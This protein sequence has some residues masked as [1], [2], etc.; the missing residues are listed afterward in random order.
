MCREQL[1][2]L[3]WS[4]PPQRESECRASGVR[5]RTNLLQVYNFTGILT[6]P[7]GVPP[8]GN[9][10]GGGNNGGNGGGNNGGGN[11]GQPVLVSPVTTGLPEPW[12]YGGC[13]VSVSSP[14]SL[15]TSD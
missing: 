5:L 8:P 10:N 12:T 1:R 3:W 15:R 6:G 13:F 2:V 7:P 14:S 11:G 9:G 4:E